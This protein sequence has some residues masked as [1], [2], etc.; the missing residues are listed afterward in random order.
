M[1][2]TYT[3]RI[4]GVSSSAAIKAPCRVATTGNVTL[5]GLQTVDGVALAAGDRVLVKAQS[6]TTENGIYAAGVSA[7]SRSSDFDGSRDV[8]TGTL[9]Y[10]TSGTANAD[11]YWT[12]TTENPVSIGTSAIAFENTVLP[13]AG[14]PAFIQTLLDDTSAGAV[15][16]TLGVSAYAQTLLDDSSAA[17]AMTTL[18]ISAFAQ[19]ILDDSSAAAAL[20]TLGVSAFA[21]TLLDDADATAALATLGISAPSA[22]TWT[23][24]LTFATPGDLSVTYATQSGSYTKIGSLVHA[25]FNIG[26]S[27]FTHTTASG[28]LRVSGLPFAASASGPRH[29]GSVL[30]S[31]YTA[32]GYHHVVAL[33]NSGQT[34]L[35]FN[36]TGSGV[37]QTNTTAAEM[38]T[39]GS[40]TWYGS[41]TYTV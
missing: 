7:W 5:S 39:G 40:I 15:L 34:Y 12:L 31:G 41:I 25:T 4:D 16:T 11:T 36:R 28:L 10:V 29:V 17:A 6:D 20:T 24:V 18:G 37:A 22:G 8:V 14:V 38:P 21:Q 9:V 30:Y 23:P 33:T 27:A 13:L 19:N 3:D 32:A 1:V 26:T 35:T 2:S